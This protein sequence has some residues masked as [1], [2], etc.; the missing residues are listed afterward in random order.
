MKFSKKSATVS[1]NVKHV[2]TFSGVGLVIP[3]ILPI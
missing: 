1:V 2:S 3:I